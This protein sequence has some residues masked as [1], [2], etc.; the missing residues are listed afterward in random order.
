MTGEA[1]LGVA[2]FVVGVLLMACG[3]YL[4]ARAIVEKPYRGDQ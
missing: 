3:I 1:I 2:L 4:I